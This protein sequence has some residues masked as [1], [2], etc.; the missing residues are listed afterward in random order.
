MS[1]RYELTKV[2]A[3]NFRTDIVR[4]AFEAAGIE[5]EV[6]RNPK[7]LHGLLAPRIDTMFAKKQIVFGENPLMRWFTN[8][9]AVKM[10]P[11]GSKQYIKKDEIYRKTDG[12]HAMLHALYRADDLLEADIG[13]SLDFLNAINF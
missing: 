8:N 7:S 12:F 3:D 6:L 11:D 5:L 13:G 9:V 1:E 4:H 2:I 10:M